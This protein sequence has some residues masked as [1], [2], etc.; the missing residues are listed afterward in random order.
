MYQYFVAKKYFF[1]LDI[2]SPVLKN[3]NSVDAT[4]MSSIFFHATSIIIWIDKNDK[5]ILKGPKDMYDFAWG[6]NGTN[7]E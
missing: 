2:S 6:S 3:E 1:T 4:F 7:K 5:V